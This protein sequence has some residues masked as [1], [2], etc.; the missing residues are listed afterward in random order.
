MKDCSLCQQGSTSGITQGGPCLFSATI[1]RVGVGHLLLT[2]AP[3]LP[4]P[5]TLLL[6]QACKWLQGT[7]LGP[8]QGRGG[9]PGLGWW[10]EA[11][12]KGWVMGKGWDVK[13]LHLGPGELKKGHLLKKRLC[14]VK[15]SKSHLK[16]CAHICVH[17]LC[18]VCDWLYMWGYAIVYVYMYWWNVCIWC[19]GYVATYVH[20]AYVYV[21][22]LCVWVYVCM[23]SLDVTLKPGKE[24]KKL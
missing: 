18:D 20:C 5:V 4:V 3:I 7:W 21:H 13:V 8:G 23:S 9:G 15:R 16:Q 6:Y 1:P 2:P 22:I 17:V 24:K 10:Q 19:V 12:R 11:E 14:F